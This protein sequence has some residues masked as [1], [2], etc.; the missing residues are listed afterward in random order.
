MSKNT[1]KHPSENLNDYLLFKRESLSNFSKQSEIC[2]STLYRFINGGKISRETA[3]KIELNTNYEITSL[4]LMEKGQIIAKNPAIL[5]ILR[6]IVFRRVSFKV[7]CM[8]ISVTQAYFRSIMLG[9]RPGKKLSKKLSKM[10]EGIVTAEEIQEGKH[11]S[12]DFSV[13]KTPPT[14]EFS[15]L[16]AIV[17][18][19]LEEE[20][21]D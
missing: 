3:L 9:K 16:L 8:M 11:V 7:F 18:S 13:I 17:K 5:L 20:D 6:I 21:Q 4:S 14:R 12:Q 19:E 2:Q 10:F 15:I 1:S